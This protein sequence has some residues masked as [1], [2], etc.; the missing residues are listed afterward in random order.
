MSFIKKL[1]IDENV[2]AVLPNVSVRYLVNN[3]EIPRK[4][5]YPQGEN[6]KSQSLVV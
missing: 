1:D 3:S 6:M 2:I 5:C 4:Y